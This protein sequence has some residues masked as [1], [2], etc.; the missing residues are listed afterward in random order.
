MRAPSLDLKKKSKGAVMVETT[1][2]AVVFLTMLFGAFDFAQFLFIH[3][4]LVERAR[5]VAR[6]GALADPTNTSAITDMMLY[7]QST[8]PPAGTAGYLGLTASNVTVSTP[9]SGTADYRLTLLISN[10]SYSMFSPFIAGSYTGPNISV[11]VP[12]GQN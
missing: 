6:W 1:L 7:N 12:L 9:G 5:Y 8:D 3:Q 11:S 10:Y 2:I 4:A